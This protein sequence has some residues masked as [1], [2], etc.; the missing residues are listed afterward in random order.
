MKPSNRH[1]PGGPSE[2]ERIPFAD[3]LGIS[4]V[5]P[6]RLR[7]VADRTGVELST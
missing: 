5:I 7:M 3:A 4:F 2:A 1:G 6:E